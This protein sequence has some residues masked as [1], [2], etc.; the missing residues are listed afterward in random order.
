M[1]RDQS[2]LAPRPSIVVLPFDNFS[3]DPEEGYFADAVTDDLTTDVSRLPRHLCD[4]TRD[5]LY[6]QR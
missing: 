5:R 1:W 6:L 2:D 3:G 4:L